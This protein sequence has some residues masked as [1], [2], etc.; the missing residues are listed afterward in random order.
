M[1]PRPE[2]DAIDK[3][4]AGMIHTGAST[5]HCYFDGVEFLSPQD[6]I[7]YV[8]KSDGD[9]LLI[10]VNNNKTGNGLPPCFPAGG[11]GQNWTVRTGPFR[12]QGNNVEVEFN[13]YVSLTL[14]SAFKDGS[15]AYDSIDAEIHG[16]I[17]N[18]SIPVTRAA[19]DILLQFDI[20]I[21]WTRDGVSHI[22]KLVDTFRD[23]NQ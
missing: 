9:K 21:D 23:K 4:I 12:V 11:E 18:S 6:V 5:C 8:R 17:V 20:T 2:S 13:D 15:E 7:L 14:L 10:D 19:K 22:I 1:G 16:W 3:S